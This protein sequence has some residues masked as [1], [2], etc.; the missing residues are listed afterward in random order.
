MRTIKSVI[1]RLY[2]D[3]EAAG[4]LCGDLQAQ[5]ERKAVYFQN[6]NELIHILHQLARVP[7]GDQNLEP[8][9][10]EHPNE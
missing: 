5:P 2:F 10:A 6:E 4:R 1:L 9:R 3:T 8:P 7:T